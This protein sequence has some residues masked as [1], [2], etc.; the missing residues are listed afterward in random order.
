MGPG[1]PCFIPP[2]ISSSPAT[3]PISC[4]VQVAS[5]FWLQLLL[6][7]VIS[8]FVML[9]F[10]YLVV[11]VGGMCVGGRAE[12]CSWCVVGVLMVSWWEGERSSAHGREGRHLEYKCSDIPSP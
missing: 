11:R 1:A 2:R 12:L 9:Y 5:G 10:H 6:V 8:A 7:L 4:R 3:L